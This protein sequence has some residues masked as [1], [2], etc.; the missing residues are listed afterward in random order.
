[1]SA[2]GDAVVVR[3]GLVLRVGWV[4][5]FLLGLASWAGLVT[6]A[7]QGFPGL[8]ADAVVVVP[9]GVGVAL[10]LTLGGV[11]VW[12]FRQLVSTTELTSRGLFRTRTITASSAVSIGVVTGPQ[13]GPRRA[14]RLGGLVVSDGG[15]PSTQLLVR[16]TDTHFPEAC[17]RLASW[18]TR[19]PELVVH[20][21]WARELLAA[22]GAS[23][24]SATGA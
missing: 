19:R 15:R 14:P 13:R 20:D 5:L 18:V 12:R 7:L 9:L 17:E 22:A 8:G 10:A 24:R 1:M 11:G 4:P 16:R 2:P 6:T 3:H 21:A 23:D